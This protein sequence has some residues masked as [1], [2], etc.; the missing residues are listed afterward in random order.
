MVQAASLFAPHALA[1]PVGDDGQLI[2]KLDRV[3]PLNGF[4]HDR[5]HD[6]VADVEATIFFA[7]S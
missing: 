3:A 4:A 2:F 1:F 5:A 7:A 6:A